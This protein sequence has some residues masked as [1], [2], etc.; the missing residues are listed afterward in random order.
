MA[1]S[2][3][4]FFGPWSSYVFLEVSELPTMPVERNCL[5]LLR[6]GVLMEPALVIWAMTLSA[7]MLS[8]SPIT[9]QFRRHRDDSHQEPVNEGRIQRSS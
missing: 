5:W 4:D 8:R 2:S 3:G 9:L 6:T 1:I 7:L